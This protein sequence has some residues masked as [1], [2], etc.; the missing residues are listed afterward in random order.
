MY[1]RY[2]KKIIIIIRN[3]SSFVAQINAKRADFKS[4]NADMKKLRVG[5]RDRV[6]IYESRRSVNELSG[7]ICSTYVCSGREPV[8]FH[9]ALQLNSRPISLEFQLN[10][11]PRV[12]IEH[13]YQ[14]RIDPLSPHPRLNISPLFDFLLRDFRFSCL[15]YY[16]NVTK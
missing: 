2:L 4:R 10:I 1:T 3:A 6:D 16:T 8:L 9:K 13:F 11:T 12:I 14:S 15:K 5:N 7:N